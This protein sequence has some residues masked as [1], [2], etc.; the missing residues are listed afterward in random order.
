MLRQPGTDPLTLALRRDGNRAKTVP[1]GR[2]T[3]NRHRRHRDMPHDR[4][5]VLGDQGDSELTGVTQRPDNELLGMTGVRRA[6][7][8]SDGYRLDRFEIQRAFLSDS[9]D[10]PLGSDALDRT[11]PQNGPGLKP[12]VRQSRDIHASTKRTGDTPDRLPSIVSP[13]TT[14]DGRTICK[15]ICDALVGK[16]ADA[17]RNAAIASARC[18][19][20]GYVPPRDQSTARWP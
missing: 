12:M 3:R 17:M 9:H 4:A 13:R 15:C 2:T 5:V 18:G 10:I 20:A 1:S 8:R 19:R 16:G 11:G 7:E 6:F 14:S